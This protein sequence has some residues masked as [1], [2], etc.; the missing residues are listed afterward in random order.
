[1]I[2]QVCPFS[3]QEDPLTPV[4]YPVLLTLPLLT[5]FNQENALQGL[6]GTMERRNHFDSVHGKSNRNSKGNYK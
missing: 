5:A 3:S 6:E 4:D 2:Q 1:M